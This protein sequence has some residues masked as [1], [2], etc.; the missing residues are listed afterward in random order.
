MEVFP[1]AATVALFGAPRALRYKKGP[2]SGRLGPLQ[3]YRDRISAHIAAECPGLAESPLGE[4]L[5]EPIAPQSGRALKDLE[6]RLDAVTCALSA[7]HIWRHG[8][9]GMQVFGECASGYIAV[10]VAIATA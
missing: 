2:L 6:D 9:A 7:Y 10:P 3:E 8:S 5:R 1:H 4:L